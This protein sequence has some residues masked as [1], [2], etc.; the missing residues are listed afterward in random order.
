MASKTDATRTFFDKIPRQWDALYAHENRVKYLFNRVVRRAIFE[1]HELTFQKCGE[2][3]GATVLDIGCGTGR[4]S[5]EFAVRGASRVMGIDFAGSMIEYA[6]SLAKDMKVEDTCEFICDDFLTREFSESFKIVIAMGLF[7]YLEHSLPVLQK[8]A[9]LTNGIFLASFPGN[10]LLWGFQR[11]IRYEWFKK[12]PIYHYNR[13]Q[14]EDLYTAASFDNVT[15]MDTS[16][17]FFVAA[18][19]TISLSDK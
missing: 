7:D 16:H 11:R 18:T 14:L 4:F 9:S 8:I 12:C 5:I 17:G 10:G 19:N 3:S 6:Q 15:I 2:I 1:R 13:E